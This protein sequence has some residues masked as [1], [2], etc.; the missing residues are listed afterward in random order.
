MKLA[1]VSRLNLSKEEI[2][3]Y[4]QQLSV[5]V[6][7]FR[8]LDEV[9]TE[10]IDPSY[11]SIEIKDSLREDKPE[12]WQWEPLSNVNEKEKGYIRGPKIK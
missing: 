1:M 12:K 9:H 5:I 8:E 10:E 6:Q 11:H 7:A 3:K 4:T 2:E